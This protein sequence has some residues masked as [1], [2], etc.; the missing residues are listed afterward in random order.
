MATFLRHF[1]NHET[2]YVKNLHVKILFLNSS[3]NMVFVARNRCKIAVTPKLDYIV[4]CSPR[5]LLIT[6]KRTYEH[7]MDL[8][9]DYMMERT[10][11]ST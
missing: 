6:R 1:C 7:N 4:A 10:D 11:P 2:Y 3:L 8:I 5:F 9:G